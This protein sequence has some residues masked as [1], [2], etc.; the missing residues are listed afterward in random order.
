MGFLAMIPDGCSDSPCFWNVSDV[1][2]APRWVGGAP[3][4]VGAMRVTLWGALA[5]GVTGS[6]SALRNCRISRVKPNKSPNT[7]LL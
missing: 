6:R 2:R 1:S 7:V 5:M 4:T 3:V